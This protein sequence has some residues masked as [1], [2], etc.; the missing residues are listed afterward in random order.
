M[1]SVMLSLGGVQDAHAVEG[2]RPNAVDSQN[3]GGSAADGQTLTPGDVAARPAGPAMTGFTFARWSSEAEPASAFDYE[4]PVAE[5]TTLDAEWV[6]PL[7]ITTTTSGS[8]HVVVFTSGS[9][10]WEVPA[11]VTELDVLVV[12]GGGGGQGYGGGGGGGGFCGVSNH[13]VTPG[14]NISVV[15][16]DGGAGSLRGAG[17][18]PYPQSSKAGDG[19]NSVFGTI[20]AYGGSGGNWVW[21]SSGAGYGRGGTSGGNNVNSIG[22]LVA[23]LPS[24]N[25][26]S[27]SGVG[28]AGLVGTSAQGGAGLSSSISGITT[29]YGGGGGALV[30]GLGGIGGGGAGHSGGDNNGYPGQTNTGGGGGA[31]HTGVGGKGGSGVV[32]VAYTAG[33]PP[34]PGALMATVSDQRLDLSWSTADGATSYSVKRSLVDGGPYTV[35]AADVTG[36]SYADTGLTNGVAYYYVVSAS[37]GE[38]ESADSASVGATPALVVPAAPT[39]LQAIPSSSQVSLTWNAPVGANGYSLKRSPNSNGPYTR[40][41]NNLA[42]TSFLDTGLANGTTYYYVVSASNGAGEGADSSVINATPEAPAPL[43]IMCVGDSITAGYTDNPS[44]TVPFQFGYRSGLYQRL[45]S[46]GFVFQFVGGSAEPWNGVFGTPANTPV[47]DLRSVNQDRH[48]GYGGQGTGHVMNN[49]A[50][51]LSADNPDIVLLMIGINDLGLHQLTS[52]KNNLNNIVDTIVSQKPAASVVV[53]QI[54]PGAN[55]GYV[56][57]EFIDYNTYIR[58]DLVPSFQQQGKRVTTVDQY[59]NFPLKNGQVDPSL[60]ANAI[61]HPTAA[62]YDRMAQTWLAGIQSA[63]Y[64]DWARGYPGFTLSNPAADADGDGLSN[65]SE[66]AFGLDP[67]RGSPSSPVTVDGML[68][69]DARFSYTRRANSALSYSV[70]TSTDLRTWTRDPDAIQT[71]GTQTGNVLQVAVALGSVPSSAKLF[72]RVQAE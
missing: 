29:W 48:R 28:T 60:F 59:A 5:N 11:G 13:I 17:T 50:A 63:D 46:A 32:I 4:L 3:N 31:G 8:N 21:T 58:E 45:T 66:Y 43:R 30:N 56:L 23:A 2:M 38:G 1:A 71:P 44:W 72:V 33:I 68:L 24:N 57:Q 39:G 15:V 6:L 36:T 64:A 65:K 27:G 26:G 47:P 34:A 61:N 62:A 49:I 41:A 22:G 7:Q 19:Q 55:N 52:A 25:Y 14:D 51:W 54:T 20:I 35:I 70:W 69:S 40:I 9:G 12:G 10:N 16:G 42:A 67:T 37:N 18:G 53:A